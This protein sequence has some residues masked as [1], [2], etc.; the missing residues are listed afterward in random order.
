MFLVSERCRADATERDTMFVDTYTERRSVI[1]ASAGPGAWADLVAL[2]AGSPTTR[3]AL[4][5][6]LDAYAPDAD[7]AERLL[8]AR[9][10]AHEA[11]LRADDYAAIARRARVGRR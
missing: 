7:T 10:C 6:W 3:R 2:Y 8:D 1:L 11:G 5:D 4:C 9:D